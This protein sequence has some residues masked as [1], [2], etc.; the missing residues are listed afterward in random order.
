MANFGLKVSAPGSNVMDAN[1]DEK[2]IFYSSK[3]SSPKIYAEGT[4]SVTI[5]D[6]DTDS[7]EWSYIH[8]LGVPLA[9]FIYYKAHVDSIDED[10]FFLSPNNVDSIMGPLFQ[11]QGASKLFAADYSDENGI[12]FQV[13]RYP[14]GSLVGDI[15]VP[16]KYYVLL[17]PLISFSGNV[18]LSN[19]SYGIKITKDGYDYKTAKEHQLSLSSNYKFFKLKSVERESGYLPYFTG[20]YDLDV[21]E[22]SFDHDL[23]YFPSFFTYAQPPDQTGSNSFYRDTP[24]GFDYMGPSDMYPSVGHIEAYVTTT[25][26]YFRASR[27]GGVDEDSVD[28]PWD[29]Q[30]INFIYVVTY[31]QLGT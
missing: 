26:F 13:Q 12:H 20:G 17:E 24:Y 23:G 2:N 15:T 31:E 10:A 4:S 16:F 19:T 9:F 1:I 14:F 28:K 18:P 30:T 3:C 6:G 29:A 25:K 27:L 22:F 5:A 11:D 21:K 8:N 7:D